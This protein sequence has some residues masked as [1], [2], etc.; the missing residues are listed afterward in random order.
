MLSPL[1]GDLENFKKNPF[2][3][4]EGVEYRIKINFKVRLWSLFLQLE[5]TSFVIGN[6]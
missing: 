1:L 5:G 2:V 3:L 6:C 4:K